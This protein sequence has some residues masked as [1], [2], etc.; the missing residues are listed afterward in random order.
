M[1][2]PLEQFEI[3]PLINLEFGNLDLSFTNSSLAMILAIG[4]A[5]WLF[6]CALADSRLVPGRWQ[7]L[8]EMIYEFVHSMVKSNLGDKGER[9]FPFIFSLFSF[10]LF[11]NL[12]GLIPYSFTATTHVIVTFTFSFSIFV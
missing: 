1:S 5:V 9:Y 11:C 4:G 8:V 7:S 6:N 12:L 2:T 10:I 3:R